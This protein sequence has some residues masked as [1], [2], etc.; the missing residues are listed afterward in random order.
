MDFLL[1]SA[2][3]PCFTAIA[4]MPKRASL[5]ASSG[6]LWAGV[7]ASVGRVVGG[8]ASPTQALARTN[9]AKTLWIENVQQWMDESCIYN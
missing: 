5:P 4:P 1:R 6:G 3:W 7:T 2:P 8:F 9:E